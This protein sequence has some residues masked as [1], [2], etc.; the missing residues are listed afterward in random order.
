[1]P[2]LPEVE[3][4]RRGLRMALTGARLIRVRLARADLRFPFP[5]GFAQR[6]EGKRILGLERRAKY[7]LAPLDSGETWITHLGMTGRFCL[8]TRS[9]GPQLGEYYYEA[10]PDPKHTHVEMETDGGAALAYNDARRFG[11]MGLLDSLALPSHPWFAS[12]GPEPLGREFHADYLRNALASRAQA[13]KPALL[14]QRLVAGLGNI[15]VCE[16]LHQ[17][18]ISPMRPARDIPLS[19]LRALARAIRA[20][21]LAAIAKGGSTLRDYAQADGSAGAF[22]DEFRVYDRAGQ[23]CLRRLCPGQIARTVQ[24]GRSSFFCP[25]CQEG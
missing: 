25:C 15:Y 13:I 16:A 9:D 14:D 10:A 8:K 17:A 7:L 2:E 24:A 11:F 23:A 3:S 18:R 19:A 5:D 1:M 20:V 22:Q 21:L 6:L 4:V 12:L